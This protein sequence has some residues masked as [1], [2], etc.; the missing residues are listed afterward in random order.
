MARRLAKVAVLSAGVILAG[1][2][3]KQ[4]QADNLADAL[5]GAYNTSGL[6]EQNRAL[7]RAADEDVAIAVSALRPIIDFSV[8]V[9]R[10]LVNSETNSLVTQTRTSTFFS[11]LEFT[12]LL[13]D[14]GASILAKQ[15]AQETVLA[16]RQ[17]LLEVEQSIL[18]RAVAAYMDVLLQEENVVLR[19]N[20]VRVLGEELRASQD[21]FE[22]GEVT[23]TDVALSESRVAAARANLADARGALTTAKAEYVNAVGRDPGRTAGQPRLPKHP[24]SINDAVA[25]AVRN[26]PSI[27]AVQH[28]V[29]AAE[30]T[31]DRQRAAL[32]PNASIRADV[33]ITNTFG[34]S[35]YN[36]TASAGLVFRQPIYAGGRLAA[37]VR[38]AMATR[39]SVKSS[40]LN[41]Q[42]DVIQAVNQAYVRFET[43]QANLRATN[44]RVRAAQVAF[45]GIREEATLGARTTLDVLTS[46]QELLDAQ[47]S[48]IQA[49]AERSLAAYQLLSA[50]GLLTAE[51][52]GLAVQIYDP[53]LYYNLVKGAPAKVSKR[54]K[55]LD[56]VLEALGKN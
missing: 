34:N 39:D 15:A 56:R 11:G 17:T 45:D 43:A 40:L 29:K 48:Q 8:R 14:G 46:E 26:H 52:L 16:T 44:E 13:Y 22:V 47:T 38:R 35:N 2:M 30:L 50:Q 24:A 6:L 41:T 49:R 18:L 9:Q 53:T 10:A 20:N 21:R 32:G 51:R 23:R 4:G 55:D 5:I 3:P 33:G 31:V 27:L 25:I 36:N 12:Q 28:Q 19:Q 54:S 42:K 1:M 7:L 37:N